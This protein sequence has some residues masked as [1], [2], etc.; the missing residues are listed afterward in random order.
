MSV[1]FFLELWD[2]EAGLFYDHLFHKRDR[3]ILKI[4]T[5]VSLVPLVAAMSIQSSTLDK[6]P[7]FTEALNQLITERQ[8]CAAGVC[9]EVG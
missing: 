8:G 2:E 5:L 7:K 4:N 1:Y 6:L 9:Y 3:H